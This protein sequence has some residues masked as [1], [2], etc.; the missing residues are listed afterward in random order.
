MVFLVV[1][2]VTVTLVG[3]IGVPLVLWRFRAQGQL[4]LLGQLAQGGHPV[5]GVH[6]VQLGRRV[7]E[8]GPHHEM[9]LG[10]ARDS[11]YR[12]PRGTLYPPLLPPRRLLARE[13]D[14]HC[15]I[16]FFSSLSVTAKKFKPRIDL[17]QYPNN[18]HCC[19][20]IIR[21]RPRPSTGHHFL[22]IH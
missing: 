11:V 17:A 20:I 1:K 7:G 21:P 3:R 15:F 10:P 6:L 8:Q 14:D 5:Q 12:L 19:K 16:S 18:C 4:G 9:R 13:T 22:L 2:L